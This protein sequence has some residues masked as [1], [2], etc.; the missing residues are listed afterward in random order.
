[1]HHPLPSCH[2]S[3]FPLC[4]S[5]FHGRSSARL[6]FTH[7]HPHHEMCQRVNSHIHKAFIPHWCNHTI[8]C[9]LCHLSVIYCYFFFPL[10]SFSLS[11]K[12]SLFRLK[13]FDCCGRQ[14]HIPQLSDWHN[15]YCINNRY[16][17]IFHTYE[18][19]K[20][21]YSKALVSSCLNSHQ[22]L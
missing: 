20:D 16:L 13:P 11:H 9:S 15:V 17:G 21:E 6:C 14:A 5:S 22:S 12:M 3:H 1:M 10:L 4:L 7:L 8:S 2:L 19:S 18:H